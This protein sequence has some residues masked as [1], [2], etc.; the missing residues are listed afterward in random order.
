MKIYKIPNKM[1]INY[2]ICN[3]IKLWLAPTFTSLFKIIIIGIVLVGLITGG[4]FQIRANIM[5]FIHTKNIVDEIR[6]R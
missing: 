4:A 6:A 5:K 1:F 3:K 2:I